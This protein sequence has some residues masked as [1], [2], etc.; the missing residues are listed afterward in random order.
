MSR[1]YIYTRINTPDQRADDHVVE[2]TDAGFTVNPQQVIFECISGGVAANARPQFSKLVEQ[3]KSGDT[4]VVTKMDGL[5]CNAMDLQKTIEQLA[6]KGFEVY[7]LVL[8]VMNLASF[9]GEQIL[10]FLKKFADFEKDLLIDRVNKGLAESR[11]NG[12]KAGRP[13][14]L[15]DKTQDE[16]KKLLASGVSVSK[17]ARDYSVSRP[18]II[19]IQT[20]ATPLPIDG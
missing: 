15:S 10:S 18:T 8:G 7:C 12:N 19:R 1:T 16:I 5:G 4:L 17:L 6:Q 13:E 11:K 2:V 9:E 3:M 20:K 14:A